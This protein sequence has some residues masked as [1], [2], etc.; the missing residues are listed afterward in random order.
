MQAKLIQV[1]HEYVKIVFPPLLSRY[2]VTVCPA[3]N[4][5]DVSMFQ[6]SVER[7]GINYTIYKT[8]IR[9][10]Y[11]ANGYLFVYG[12]GHSRDEVEFAKTIIEMAIGGVGDIVNAV[13]ESLPLP[14]FEEVGYNYP[15]PDFATSMKK[16][17]D[18]YARLIAAGVSFDICAMAREWTGQECRGEI[19]ANPANLPVWV[20]LAEKTHAGA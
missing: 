10:R 11:Y 15:A 4:S 19:I 6:R 8:P 14:L 3:T 1:P 18:I 12:S 7:V 16:L 5:V 20:N 2:Q 17:L 13:Y 9:F